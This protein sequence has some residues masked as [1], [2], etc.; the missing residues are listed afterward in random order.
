MQ[1][2]KHSINGVSGNLKI[3]AQPGARAAGCFYTQKWTSDFRKIKGYGAGGEMN[4]SIRFDDE[5]R[6]GHNSFAITA[7]VYSDRSRRMND[8]EAGGCMHEEIARVFPELAGFVQWHLFNAHEPMHY[9]ANTL[10]HATN[11]ANSSYAPG[12]ACQ[13][14]TRVKFEGFPV[15]FKFSKAFR[16]FL[17]TRNESIAR[18]PVSPVAVP[19]VKR[20]ASDTYQFEP[21]YTVTGFDVEKWHD[22]PFKDLREARE[23]CAAINNHVMTFER[24]ATKYAEEKTRNLKAARSCANWPE[25]TDAELCAPRDELEAALKARLPALMARFRAAIENEAGMT[26]EAQEGLNV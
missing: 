24:I 3:A 9:I 8:I 22:A 19:Y 14:E 6:N 12:E 17:Q 25:A 16:E 11:W 1:T 2:V 10:Y 7:N 23:F 15:T 26:Y 13:W 20:D 18:G 5:C 21:H 4:V